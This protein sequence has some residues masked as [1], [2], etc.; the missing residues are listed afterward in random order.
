M[1]TA[2]ARAELLRRFPELAAKPVVTITNGFDPAD[3]AA[4][5][6]ATD[7]DAFRIVHAGW[8]HTAAGR[9]HRRLRLARRLLG[10]A[11][12]GLDILARSET[13]LLAAIERL[14]AERP[15]LRARL[16]LHLAGVASGPGARRSPYL[17][18]HGY[19][20]HA[21]TIALLRSADL[22]FLPMH[23]LPPGR[24]ARIVPG[25][26]YEYLASGRPILAAVPDGDARDLL[27]RAGS[28][29]LCRPADVGAM[30]RLIAAQVDR[31]DAGKP[32]PAPD[33]DVLRD[34]ERSRLTAALAELFDGVLGR[35]PNAAPELVA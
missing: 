15:E 22:L 10:G 3:F 14:L 2:E 17:H 27:A 24:R 16:E 33:P 23:D 5:P 19:L 28:A 25:K 30:T 35:R 26:T 20:A 18:A 29:L 4:P 32:A 11:T 13:Y 7:G 12:P 6:P 34:Y 21:E 8:A 1:N 9:R 31:R